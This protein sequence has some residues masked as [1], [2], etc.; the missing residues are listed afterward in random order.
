MPFDITNEEYI[1]VLE[2][3]KENPKSRDLYKRIGFSEESSVW[4]SIRL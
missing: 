3:E 1:A 2:T 4:M